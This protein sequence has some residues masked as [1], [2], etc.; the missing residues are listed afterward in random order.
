MLIRDKL[1]AVFMRRVVRKKSIFREPNIT[2]FGI[3]KR[4]IA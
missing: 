4:F 1:I 3:S 2:S